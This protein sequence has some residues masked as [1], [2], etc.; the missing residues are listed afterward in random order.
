MSADAPGCGMSDHLQMLAAWCSPDGP[1][2]LAGMMAAL[3][4]AGLVGSAVH[5]AP[6]CG[7]FVLSQVSGNLSRISATR[8][9]ERHRVSAGLLL[10]YH[11]GRISTYAALGALSAGTSALLQNLPALRWIPAALLGLA[12]LLFLSQALRRLAPAL[13][14]GLPSLPSPRLAVFIARAARR[15]SPTGPRT[16]LLLGM[17]LGLLPCGFLYAALAAAAATASPWRGAAAMLAFGLGTAPVL[18]LLGIAGQAA[19]RR[20]SLAM[21]TIGPSL[22][23]LN[24]AVLIVMSGIGLFG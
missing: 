15:I 16:G 11:A 10:P 7:P 24:A 9:C 17:V 23:L 2:G 20:W 5:C 18:M 4:L 14:L 3:F 13:Q 1:A 19:N 6:M 8:L 12:G 22:L 21:A